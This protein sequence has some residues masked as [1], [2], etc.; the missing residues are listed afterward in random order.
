MVVWENPNRLALS[1]ILKPAHQA[2]Q[3]MPHSKSYKS[4]FFRIVM[5]ALKQIVK[6]YQLK[7]QKRDM[8][9]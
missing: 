5:L 7:S 4:H 1:E 3:T 9:T 6:L 8:K 2:P